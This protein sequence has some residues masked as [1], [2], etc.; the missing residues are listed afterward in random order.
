MCCGVAWR[1]KNSSTLCIKLYWVMIKDKITQ[2]L[3]DTDT[4]PYSNCSALALSRTTPWIL[5]THMKMTQSG[6]LL[7][8]FFCL[9]T[10][11]L[12]FS[13]LLAWSSSAIPLW[14]L[15]S[16][17]HFHPRTVTNWIFSLYSNSLIQHFEEPLILL[18]NT[19]CWKMC[20]LLKF[21]K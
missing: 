13:F 2:F 16:A 21:Q 5:M 18:T 1:E 11:D 19:L 8:F 3:C 6:L 4:S 17:R 7:T 9:V 14:P 12:F 15:A 10:F 20:E